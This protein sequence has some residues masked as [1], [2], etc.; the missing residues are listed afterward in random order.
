LYRYSKAL[1]K[2]NVKKVIER[3]NVY[4]GVAYKVRGGEARG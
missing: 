1:Y 2:A 4:T 3:V